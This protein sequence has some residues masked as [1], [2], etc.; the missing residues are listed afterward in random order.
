MKGLLMVGFELSG[1]HY[2]GFSLRTLKIAQTVLSKTDSDVLKASV[3]HHSTVKLET[4]WGVLSYNA[5]QQ[6]CSYSK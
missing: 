1:F 2:K 3:L 4:Q 5:E 6:D